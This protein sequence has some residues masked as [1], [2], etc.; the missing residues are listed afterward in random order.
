M[1]PWSTG[2]LSNLSI[3][4][5]YAYR[6][7]LLRQRRVCSTT[8][9][10]IAF[11][12]PL[13]LNTKFAFNDM[14]EQ[15]MTNRSRIT[16]LALALTVFLVG[17]VLQSFAL[18]GN[19][20]PIAD[21]VDTT[22]PH[23]S[24]ARPTAATASLDLFA[25]ATLTTEQATQPEVIFLYSFPLPPGEPSF[26]GLKGPVSMHSESSAF[27][28]SLTTVAYNTSGPCPAD[29]TVFPNY[30]AIY[31]AYPNLLP[32]Q[33]FILKNPTH[34]TS[35]VD[36]DYTMPVGVPVSDCIV[37]MLDWEGSSIV[38]MN[39]TLKMSYTTDPS[40][41]TG[42]LLQTNQEF[43]FG[44]NIG[45][46]STKNDSLSFVQETKITEP[47]T[48]LAFVGDISDSTFSIPPPPGH[49]HTTNDI[50]LVP[51]GCPSDIHVN[52]GGWTPRAGHYYSDTPP[53]ALH[54]LSA[55][56]PGFQAMAAQKFIYKTSHV[57]VKTGDCLLTLFGLNAPLGGGIDS[58]NQVKALFLPAQ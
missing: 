24:D 1:F 9:G 32:V 37:L 51:G 39:S 56:L 15:T 13:A 49:W 38:T 44:I 6:A 18:D 29:G 26:L 41:P 11:D 43:V 22:T 27:N 53:D 17:V 45:P 48:L 58:E 30:T 3:L 31:A 55:P 5:A 23:L 50:Y 40:S 46:G 8:G 36:I 19:S 52:S 25:S 4:R 7:Q 14:R 21:A 47:G 54:L 57:K 20:T 16:R 34:G 42:T 2:P 33:S 12:D 35:K 10:I 28:E